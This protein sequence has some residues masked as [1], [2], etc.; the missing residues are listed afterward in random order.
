MEACAKYQGLC[1][2]PNPFLYTWQRDRT[3][4][5]TGV[6][7]PVHMHDG[8]P[9][10]LATF[11]GGNILG[12]TVQGSQVLLEAKAL[13]LLYYLKTERQKDNERTRKWLVHFLDQFEDM[14]EKLA[15][16]KVQVVYFTS[17]SRQLEFEKTSTTVMPL[18]H[19]AYIL[20]IVFTVA[21]CFSTTRLAAFFCQ[22]ASTLEPDGPAT[23]TSE[24]VS[25]NKTS[26]L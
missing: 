20:V 15:L 10:S 21:S 1:V 24:M 7:F 11:F 16:K 22:D 25:K 23:E 17:L 18:F 19:W 14:K 3:L 2:P 26:L 12:E 13:Q 8:H 6:S 4:N 5:Q 9:V